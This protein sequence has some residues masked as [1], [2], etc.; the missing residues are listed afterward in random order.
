MLVS[1]QRYRIITDRAAI[2]A[3]IVLMLSQWLAPQPFTPDSD[4]IHVATAVIEP[5]PEDQ[6]SV[7]SFSDLMLD[8]GLL[9]FLNR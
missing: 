5:A 2:V 1:H 8:L 9:L 4:T 6:A 7:I 3:A